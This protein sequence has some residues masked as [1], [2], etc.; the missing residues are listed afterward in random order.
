M[1]KLVDERGLDMLKKE[2]RVLH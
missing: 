2:I 1:Y